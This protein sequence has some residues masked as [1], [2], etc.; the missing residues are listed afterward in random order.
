LKIKK[1][2][3]IIIFYLLKIK[4]TNELNIYELKEKKILVRERLSILEEY[5][6]LYK[7]FR[8]QDKERQSLCNRIVS[9]FSCKK[10]PS[11]EERTKALQFF[12]NNDKKLGKNKTNEYFFE[13]KLQTNFLKEIINKK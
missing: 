8:R 12:L 11:K 3:P 4:S 2:L 10:G 6:L 7:E 5:F 13:L 1:I 9:F